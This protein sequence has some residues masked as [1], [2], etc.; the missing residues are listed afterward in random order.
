MNKAVA[1]AVAATIALTPTRASAIAEAWYRGNLKHIHHSGQRIIDQKFNESKSQLF[2]G[3]ISR[4]WGKSFWAV[5]KAVA[6]ALMKPKAR[7]KFGTAFQ[8][9]LV[10]FILPTFDAVLESCPKSLRPKYKVQGSKWV[11]TNGAEIKLVGLD[12]SPNSMRGNVIDLIILD[13]AGFISNLEY[14]Y[15]SIIV[16]ATLHRP[17]CK[18]IMISTPPSTPAHA[19][20]DFIHKAEVEGGYVKLDIYTNPRIGQSDIDRMAKELGGFEST[21]FRRECLCELVTDS[22]SQIIPEWKDSYVVAT[23]DKDE[24]R[25]FYHNYVSMDLGVKDFTLVLLGHYDFRRATLVV[26]DEIKLNGPQLTTLLLKDTIVAKEKSLWLAPTAAADEKP[27]V[28]RR[29]SDNNNPQLIQDLAILHRIP[30]ISTD[31]DKLETMINE[32]RMLIDQARVEVDPRCEQLIG[33]LKYGVW[34]KKKKAFAR[35]S[36]YGHFDALAA[37]VYLCRNL[38][39][40]TNPIPHTYGFDARNSRIKTPKHESEGAKLLGQLFH[41][42]TKA[43]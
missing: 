10:E 17:N 21:A 6:L 39:K 15:K 18:I 9:D 37:L 11:F 20:V 34:D 31:K 43:S 25:R 38:D 26:E 1:L 2:V 8:T 14:I 27:K 23:R 4:Q 32:T 30:F 24:Y 12:K 22:D 33:C 28:Y 36:A 19:F 3:N 13:E 16:P 7:I 5:T 41:K 35:S 40:H 42:P 29:I